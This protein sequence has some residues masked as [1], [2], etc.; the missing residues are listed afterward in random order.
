VIERCWRDKK[1]NEV[2]ETQHDSREREKSTEAVSKG[3]RILQVRAG[4]QALT[5]L[6]GGWSLLAHVL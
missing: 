3:R 1:A 2:A 6:W 5:A 4:K